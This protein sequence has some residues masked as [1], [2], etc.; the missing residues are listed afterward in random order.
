MRH[1]LTALVATL[2]IGVPAGAQPGKTSPPSRLSMVQAQCAG[3]CTCGVDADC[4][5]GGSC[6]A[7]F[8]T[9]GDAA[10]KAC[11]GDADCAASRT[12]ALAPGPCAPTFVVGGGTVVLR[13]AKQPSPTRDPSQ[14]N[15]G[16][17]TL[18]GLTQNGAPYSGTLAGEVIL[19]PTFGTD[20]NGNCAL[21]AFQMALPSETS[22]LTCKNGKCKGRILPA[23]ALPK[24]CADVSITIELVSI[25]IRDGSGAAVASAGLFIPAGKSDAP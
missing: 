11:N 22:T 14:Q 12:C 16:Q 2:V 17:M 3:H 9:A 25:T 23:F 24:T 10:R 13:G 7:G 8:C 5:T 19:K 18:T 6:G 21:N 20:A 4:G 1:L 15:A